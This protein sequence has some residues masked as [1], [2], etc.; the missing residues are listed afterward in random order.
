VRT[1]GDVGDLITVPD[2]QGTLHLA[3]AWCYYPTYQPDTDDWPNDGFHIS[4]F[5]DHP[6]ESARRADVWLALDEL[7][8][9]IWYL[10]PF[11]EQLARLQFDSNQPLRAAVED[12]LARTEPTT[13]LTAQTDE[14]CPRSGQWILRGGDYSMAIQAGDPMPGYP[15][16]ET[17]PPLWT[18][19]DLPLAEPGQRA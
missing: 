18:R 11:R 7:A 3:H 5:S 17:Y 2:H 1:P 16:F 4:Y 9:G 8:D 10:T 12:A 14:P 19:W 15:F 6:G 13:F